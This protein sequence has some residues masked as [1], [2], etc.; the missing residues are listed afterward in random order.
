MSKSSSPSKPSTAG[1]SKLAIGSTAPGQ[2]QGL[3]KLRKKKRAANLNRALDE[4]DDV[5][6]ND[7]V[8][9]PSKRRRIVEDYD[10]SNERD[11]DGEGEEDGSEDDDDPDV[12]ADAD[13]DGEDVQLPEN[14]VSKETDPMRLEKINTKRKKQA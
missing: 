4:F 3:K 2:P 10:D 6:D 9:G 5:D 7:L 14:Q 11:G 12:D 8:A 1:P 13:Q